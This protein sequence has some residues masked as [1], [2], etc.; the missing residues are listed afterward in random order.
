MKPEFL[1]L[2]VY[3]LKGIK[4]PHGNPAC[5]AQVTRCMEECAKKEL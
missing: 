4:V 5:I 1:V 3:E 2:V